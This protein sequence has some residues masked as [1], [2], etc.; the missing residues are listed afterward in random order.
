MVVGLERERERERERESARARERERDFSSSF[1]SF[2]WFQ[3]L[4]LTSLIPKPQ[5]TRNRH[6]FLYPSM[7]DDEFALSFGREFGNE[8]ALRCQNPWFLGWEDA[9]EMWTFSPSADAAAAA[10]EEEEEE[11]GGEGT[12]EEGEEREEE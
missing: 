2:S 12:G 4:S 8:K 11:E 9:V 3:I 6:P 1:S 5:K 10:A 7:T